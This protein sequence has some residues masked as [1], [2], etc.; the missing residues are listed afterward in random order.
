ME[1]FYVLDKRDDDDSLAWINGLSEEI[2]QHPLSYQL[3]QPV[4]VKSW[5]PSEIVIPLDINR[6]IKLCDAIPAYGGELVV[7]E[8]LK[9]VLIAASGASFEFYPVQLKDI[10][11]RPIKAPYFL[12]HLLDVQD[13]LDMEKSIYRMSAVI[14]HEVDRFGEIV[15]D[16]NKL[17]PNKKIFRLK[18]K[19]SMILVRED[20]VDEILDAEECYGPAFEYLEDHGDIFRDDMLEDREAGLGR[21]QI[22][23]GEHDPA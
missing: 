11:D 1:Q 14:K 18:H 9:N 19:P 5:M 16:E 4:S 2:N 8:K 10:K 20:L 12:A 3:T 23:R 6:G 17:D 22:Y 21:F 15:L 7:S 13:C